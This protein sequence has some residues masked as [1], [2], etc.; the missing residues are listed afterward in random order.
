MNPDGASW[1]GAVLGRDFAVKLSPLG[2]M[3]GVTSGHPRG[4]WMASDGRLSGIISVQV[5]T[6]VQT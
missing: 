3:V 4:S 5:D 6:L 2:W 1:G